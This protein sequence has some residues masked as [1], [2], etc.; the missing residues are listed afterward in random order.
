MNPSRI[1]ALCLLAIAGSYGVG[2]AQDPGPW[3]T[4]STIDGNWGGY[5]RGHTLFGFKSGNPYS[6][7]LDHSPA[8]VQ[9]NLGPVRLVSVYV[10]TR[11]TVE[12]RIFAGNCGVRR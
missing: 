2:R 1:A 4:W 9:S 10:Q 12:H 6:I 8:V 7:H 11:P 5:R 3:R